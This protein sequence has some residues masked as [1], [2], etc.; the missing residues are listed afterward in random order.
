MLWEGE[1]R[2]LDVVVFLVVNKFLDIIES[3]IHS[4]KKGRATAR[5][6]QGTGFGFQKRKALEKSKKFKKWQS[7]GDKRQFSR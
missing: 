4:S 1:G 7:V 2:G 6:P 3:G 5:Q